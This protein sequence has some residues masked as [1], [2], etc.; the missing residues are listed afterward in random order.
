MKQG[1]CSGFELSESRLDG[2]RLRQDIRHADSSTLIILEGFVGS[3]YEGRPIERLDCETYEA[4]ALAEGER[5][6]QEGLER[7]AICDVMIVQRTG[8]L[9]VG[10]P[11]YWI[12]ITSSD[13]LAAQSALQYFSTQM[14][15]RIPLW[16]KAFFKDGTS[17]W[18]GEQVAAGPVSTT[19]EP[20]KVRSAEMEHEI[21]EPQLSQVPE[22]SSSLYYQKM[23]AGLGEAYLQKLSQSS[24]LVV[25][26]GSLGNAA[27]AYLASAGVGFLGICDAERLQAHQVYRQPLYQIAD[28]GK[29]KAI[30]AA[31]RLSAM[32][33]FVRIQAHPKKLERHNVQNLLA[34][35]DLVLDCTQDFQV[36]VLLNEAAVAFQKPL[37]QARVFGYEGQMHLYHPTVGGCLQCQW[38]ISDA[39]DNIGLGAAAGTFGALQAAEAVKLL[40]GLS[41]PLDRHVLHFNLITYQAHL[42]PRGTNPDCP[43]C[44]TYAQQTSPAVANENLIASSTDTTADPDWMVFIDSQ[45]ETQ[46]SGYV[47][48]DV[49]ETREHKTFPGHPCLNMPFSRF[50]LDNPRLDRNHRYLLYCQKGTRS[51]HLTRELRRRGITNVFALAGGIARFSPLEQKEKLANEVQLPVISLVK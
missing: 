18:C 5:L 45:N 4:L 41:T 30:L 47:L 37:I 3:E 31:E 51:L 21:F 28:I 2:M 40:T 33:P 13:E 15:Q 17:V 16:C 8:R 9:V 48:V 6:I 44:Q 43:V 29:S 12:G 26:A 10:E 34:T 39:P 14:K 11:F 25:G 22:S 36:R 7:F 50:N 23:L 46:L 32:N 24:V 35:H 49:S 42:L 20:L 1:L 27:L 38:P 19:P